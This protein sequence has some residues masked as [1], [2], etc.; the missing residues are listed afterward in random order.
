MNT[1]SPSVSILYGEYC[2]CGMP[3]YMLGNRKF[4]QRHGTDIQKT[5]METLRGRYSGKSHTPYGGYEGR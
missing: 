1:K 5:T 2:Y 3:L 4:C